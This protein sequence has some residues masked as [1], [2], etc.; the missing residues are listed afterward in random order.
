LTYVNHFSY[1]WVNPA[2]SVTL[3]VAGCLLGIMLASKARRRSPLGRARLLVYA[4]IAFGGIGIW[5]SQVIALL[6]LTIPAAVVRYDPA[7]L[8]VSLAV[9]LVDVGTGLFLV[10]RGRLVAGTLIPA[11]LVL[12][13]G[14]AATSYT[15]LVALR[16]SAVIA[17]DPLRFSATVALCVLLAPFALWSIAALRGLVSTV[18]TSILLGLVICGINYGGQWAMMVYFRQSV[19]GVP[20]LSAAT[21][22]APLI[23][24]GCTVAVMLAYFTIGS[25]TVRELRSIYDPHGRAEEAIEPWLIEEV[26]SRVANGTTVSPL[27]AYLSSRHIGRSPVAGRARPSPGI[28]PTWQR[29]PTWAAADLARNDG[30][31]RRTWPT[32]A[33]RPVEPSTAVTEMAPPIE[34]SSVLPKRIVSS[35]PAAASEPTVDAPAADG[36]ITLTATATVVEEVVPATRA[37]NSRRWRNRRTIS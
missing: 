17:F 37:P 20:G 15:I 8:G 21:L 2:L 29:T 22:M 30:D 6:G 27:P 12:G 19:G 35:P 33:P 3:A 16:A 11:G 14:A 34:V 5:L 1:G 7:M 36:V 24:G 9:A 23:L 4:T 10:T 13:L 28:R 26:T 32:A 18:V 31:H 25:S